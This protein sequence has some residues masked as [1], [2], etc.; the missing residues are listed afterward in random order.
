MHK[1]G[2]DQCSMMSINGLACHEQGCP[3]DRARWDAEEERWVKQRKCGVCGYR[4]DEDD[5]CCLA[6]AEYDM[7]ED[8]P[9]WADV[10]SE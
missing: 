3:N 4:V 8:E 2:C 1:F 10:P 5:A 9:Q 6:E 7:G